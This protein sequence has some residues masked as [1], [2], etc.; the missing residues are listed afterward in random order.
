[1]ESLGFYNLFSKEGSFAESI[2][3]NGTSFSSTAAKFWPRLIDEAKNRFPN[4]SVIELS[5]ISPVLLHREMLFPEKALQDDIDSLWNE[6]FEEMMTSTIAEMEMMGPPPGVN[7]RILENTRELVKGTL[8][9][10]YIDADILPDLIVWLLEWACLP[11][12]I[13]NNSNVSGN[14]TAIDPARNHEYKITF[15]VSNTE[16]SEGLRKTTI[17]LS[18]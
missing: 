7:I 9:T 2:Y 18:L 4:C 5:M 16:M 6:D 12:N 8:P 3:V 1:M 11:D 14:F 17:S 15:T 13:W 10:E